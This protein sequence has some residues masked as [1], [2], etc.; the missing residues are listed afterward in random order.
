MTAGLAIV[1][2]RGYLVRLIKR[3]KSID[4][5]LVRLATLFLLIDFFLS[6][7]VH[8]QEIM[9]IKVLLIHQLV[10]KRLRP[11]LTAMHLL[12]L[13]NYGHAYSSCLVLG[14]IG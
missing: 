11:E 1:V 6:I 12:G 10:R 2:L 4:F 13:A 9:L 3:L 8:L 14:V 7:T 5:Y